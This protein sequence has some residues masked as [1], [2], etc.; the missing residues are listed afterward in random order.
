MPTI[1][2]DEGARDRRRAGPFW[3]EEGSGPLWIGAAIVAAVLGLYSF[4]VI[5]NGA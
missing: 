1:P 2:L 3:I 5:L 4:A